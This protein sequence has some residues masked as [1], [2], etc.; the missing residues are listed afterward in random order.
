MYVGVILLILCL[1]LALGS[2]YA[3]IPSSLITLLFV[4]RTFLEDKTLHAELP[5]YKEYADRVRYKLI[6]GLW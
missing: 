1:P 3:L 6:P 2:F 5:G 4:L